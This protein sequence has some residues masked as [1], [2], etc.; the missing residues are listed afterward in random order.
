MENTQTAIE[1]SKGNQMPLVVLQDEN[2]QKLD[3]P[4]T[5]SNDFQ[6]KSL[7]ATPFTPF[8]GL[9]KIGYN[10]KKYYSN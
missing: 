7:I 9:S 6:A 2:I 8:P 3:D 5:L 1:F 4:N 10:I